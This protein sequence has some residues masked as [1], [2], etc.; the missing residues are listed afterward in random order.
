VLVTHVLRISKHKPIERI[1]KIC[2]KIGEN[3]LTTRSAMTIAK[4]DVK[5]IVIPVLNAPKIL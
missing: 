5:V 3:D 1:V 2:V 4:R